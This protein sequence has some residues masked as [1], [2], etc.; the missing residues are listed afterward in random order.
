M[1]RFCCILSTSL[2]RQI[3]LNMTTFGALYLIL[4]R[5][6][7]NLYHASSSNEEWRI[8]LWLYE[9]TTKFLYPQTITTNNNLR[10]SQQGNIKSPTRP[11]DVR[12]NLYPGPRSIIRSR[13][14]SRS[15]SNPRYN[16]PRLPNNVH[17]DNRLA[18]SK[19]I[20]PTPKHNK[21]R[22]TMHEVSK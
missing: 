17:K 4:I 5:N 21:I 7:E 13:F 10:P 22:F 18:I 11:D 20:L 1:F 2:L 3:N 12:C 8:S 16:G 6:Q 14:L 15:S 19:P 9:C